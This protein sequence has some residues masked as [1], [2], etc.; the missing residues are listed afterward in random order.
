M[1]WERALRSRLLAAAPIAAFVSARVDW[2]ERP[3]G[4]PL[5]AIT[6]QTIDEP[7]VQHFDGIDRTQEALVQIDAW[8]A[9]AADRKAL[10]DAVIATLVP[11]QTQDG[12][13]FQRGFVRTRTGSE[14]TES[15]TVFR[16]SM[17]FDLK[18]SA[19]EEG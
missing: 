1:D 10:K 6:L 4:K 3:Q 12:V 8:A 14:Q 18:F 9:T 19:Q 7:T 5:P 15:G 16:A 11:A 17:D 2:D 13:R